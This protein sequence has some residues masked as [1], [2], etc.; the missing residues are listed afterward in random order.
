MSWLS[1][2]NGLRK[3]WKSNQIFRTQLHGSLAGALYDL[4]F[5]SLHVLKVSYAHE[6]QQILSFFQHTF[7]FLQYVVPQL[8]L[9]F[10][11]SITGDFLLRSCA[12][13]ANSTHI[14]SKWLSRGQRNEHSIRTVLDTQLCRR[15]FR[16]WNR[17]RVHLH[18]CR[19]L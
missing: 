16:F 11:S 5:E 19:H 14:K 10:L 12:T 7:L 15:S 18:L 17:R 2:A 13:K 6:F 8:T 3:I 1:I 4:E 9:I